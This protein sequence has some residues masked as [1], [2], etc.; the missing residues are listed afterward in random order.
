[1]KENRDHGSDAQNESEILKK[2]MR[3]DHLHARLPP[4]KGAGRSRLGKGATGNL[5]A[6]HR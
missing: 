2:I 3:C 1:L 6:L 5:T 4:F